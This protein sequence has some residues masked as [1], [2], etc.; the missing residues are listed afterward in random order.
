MT[1]DPQ[2]VSAGITSLEGGVDGGRPPN[3][4]P[5]NK[6]ADALNAT[7]RGG[8][9]RHRLPYKKL[10][11]TMPSGRFQHGAFF[12]GSSSPCLIAVISGRFYRIS[13]TDYSVLEFTPNND[14]NSAR[15]RIGWSVTADKWWIYQDN[16]N[17]P[18]I[19]DGAGARRSDVNNGEIPTGNVMSYGRGRITLALPDRTSFRMGDLFGSSSGTR[20]YDYRDSILK[21][22]ENSYLNEGGDFTARVFG[23]PLNAG[24]IVAIT[25]I[26]DLDTSLGQGP[27]MVF[28]TNC[29]F[30]INAPYD[31]TVWK[32]L[33]SPIQT[34][35]MINY[36]ATGQNS[37]T[38]VNGDIFYRSLDGIR[39][40]IMASR[41]FSSWGNTPVSTEIGAYLGY[42]DSWLLE[43]G[44]SVVFDNRLIST[45]SPVMTTYGVYHRGLAVLDFDLISSMGERSRPAWEGIWTGLRVLQLVKGYKG[46]MERL[47]IFALNSSNEIELWEMP[48]TGNEDD[49]ITTTQPITWSISGRSDGFGS[50]RDLKILKCGELFLDDIQG[51]VTAAVQYR[52]DQQYAIRDWHTTTVCSDVTN[53]CTTDCVTPSNLRAQVR[54][55]IRLPQPSEV[56]YEQDRKQ[57]RTFFEVQP[58]IT[59]TG[60]CRL[61]ALG[62]H[63][64]PM[65]ETDTYEEQP[66]TCYESQAGSDSIL[67]S[68]VIH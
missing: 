67:T 12:D 63:A 26:A 62:M 58:K 13:L 41:D 64:K 14:A 59:L 49:L 9:A 23:S 42:D 31:R 7:F 15:K 6:C 55:K 25:N 5:E 1:K 56:A 10:N 18:L 54:A 20:L 43:W 61:R 48:K 29:V 68:N 37:T 17:T 27:T 8:Y 28:T 66:S 11:A 52:E 19:Y 24:P 65:P 53:S 4:L 2:R 50:P 39:S 57:T 21:F 22:T 38:L 34:V 44:S 36:G 30:S 16:E 35:A 3:L 40:L 32:E 46:G 33:N 60:T 47:W 45:I 51:S